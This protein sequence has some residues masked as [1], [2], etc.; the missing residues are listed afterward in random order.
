MI[1]GRRESWPAILIL[2]IALVV[3]AMAL[4]GVQGDIPVDPQWLMAADVGLLLVMALVMAGFTWRCPVAFGIMLAS[5]A[6]LALLMGWGYSAVEGASRAPYSAIQHGLWDYLPGTALQLGF[7]VAVGAVVVAWLTGPPQQLSAGHPAAE[8]GAGEPT[9]PDL[10]QA[11]GPAEAVQWACRVAGVGAALLAQDDAVFAAGAWERDPNAAL[12]RTMALARRVGQGL[13]SYHLDGA[14]LVVRWE[15]AHVVALLATSALPPEI[16][17]Q[18][19]RDLWAWEM[20]VD[21]PAAVPEP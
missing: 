17:H 5:Q 16:V 11:D 10:A 7:A 14:V 8:T 18:L 20:V 15:E 1:L 9:L 13:N 3:L 12:T 19:V 6:L 4:K 2:G 21:D